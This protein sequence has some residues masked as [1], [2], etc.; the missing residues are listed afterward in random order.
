[1]FP[2]FVGKLKNDCRLTTFQW[3]T[4]SLVVTYD[5]CFSGSSATKRR[6]RRNMFTTN[7]KH[8][9]R[10]TIAQQP[11]NR[12]NNSPVLCPWLRMRRPRNTTGTRLT[13]FWEFHSTK[14]PMVTISRGNERS[15][16]TTI[17]VSFASM[18][19]EFN[20]YYL[21]ICS[22]CS[23]VWYNLMTSQFVLIKR[24][25]TWLDIEV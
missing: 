16:Y 24:N 15:I 6:K 19:Y 4:F 20:Q 17:R 1:M 8:N 12:H 9:N 13:V 21:S 7:N 25:I 14:T 23:T 18:C 3:I 11:V 22:N 10:T 5:A 2:P